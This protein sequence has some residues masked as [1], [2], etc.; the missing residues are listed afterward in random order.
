MAPASR[1]LGYDTAGNGDV[2]LL[3]HGFPLDRTMWA[4]QLSGLSDVRKV[5]AIDLRGRGKSPDEEAEDWAIDLYADDIAA[6]I[7]SLGVDKVD[8]AGLS[9]GGYVCFS[10]LRRYAD[11]VRSLILIDTKAAGDAPEA[12]E[13]REKTAAMVREK[14]ISELVEVLL[15]KLLTQDA[16]EAVREKGRAIFENVPRET[17]AADSLAMRDRADYTPDLAS[18]SVPTLVIHGEQDQIMPIDAA[19][20]MAEAIPG[21]EFMGIAN[22]GH[23]A[24]IE[25]P[26]GVNNAIR[27]FLSS[28]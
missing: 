2:L 23:L 17:A 9:M 8:L 4:E 16:N 25:N 12:K 26:D 28:S 10:L 14:G 6:T 7:D 21:A 19:R 20:Q 13:A 22:A 5:V 3:V 18:I 24:P 27:E 11:K 15:P 1:V